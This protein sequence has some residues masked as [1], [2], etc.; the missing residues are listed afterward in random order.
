M[1]TPARAGRPKIGFSEQQVVLVGGCVT[2]ASTD[3]ILVTHP[4]RRANSNRAKVFEKGQSGR[5]STKPITPA[6]SSPY[7]SV[8]RHGARGGKARHSARSRPDRSD[9]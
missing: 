6:L 4:R 1:D 9:R 7:L 5:D 3:V 2:T 8:T